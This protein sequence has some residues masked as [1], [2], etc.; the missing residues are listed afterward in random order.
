MRVLGLWLIG[1]GTVA[2]VVALSMPTSVD[3]PLGDVANLDLMHRQQMYLIVAAVVALSGVITAVFSGAPAKDRLVDPFDDADR[4]TEIER[5]NHA[6]SLGVTRQ[7]GNYHFGDEIFADFEAA[8][9]AAEAHRSEPILSA[10][11]RSARIEAD[12]AAS[13]NLDQ[14]ILTL[15]IFLIVALVVAWRIF[16]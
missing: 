11:Q 15:G 12:R 9:A 8:V 13:K 14:I 4:R 1:I 6:V 16:W 5:K 3:S 7:A 2:A 10:Q